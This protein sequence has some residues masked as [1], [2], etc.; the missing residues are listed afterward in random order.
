MLAKPGK[1]EQFFSS[2]EGHYAAA[3]RQTF[4]G[5]WGLDEDQQDEETKLAI[6]VTVQLNSQKK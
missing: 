2:E 1:V 3:I 6:E 4:A 5:L